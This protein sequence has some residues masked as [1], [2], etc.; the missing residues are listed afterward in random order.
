M[1]I[2]LYDPSLL[3]IGFNNPKIK[4]IIQ[5]NP[6]LKFGFQYPQ[7]FLSPQMIQMAQNLFKK[8]E[9]NMIESSNTGISVS[10]NP[11]E[12]SQILNSSGK[13]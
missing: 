6:F 5:N 4:K 12:N 10:P 1:S 3:E 8:D 7:K 9:N 13:K 11:F 2:I